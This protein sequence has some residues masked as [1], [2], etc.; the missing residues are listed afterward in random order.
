MFSLAW[1][2]AYSIAILI[3]S[4]ADY[5]PAVEN[6]QN[7]GFKIVN[8]TWRNLGHQLAKRCWASFEMDPLNNQLIRENH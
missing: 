8:A 3:S 4:D 1:A 6:L 7:K 2:G 5:V